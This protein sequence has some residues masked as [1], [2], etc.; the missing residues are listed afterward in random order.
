M[1]PNYLPL[2]TLVKNLGPQMTGLIYDKQAST[3][4]FARVF[5]E[6]VTTLGETRPH[7]DPIP[8]YLLPFEA[9]LFKREVPKNSVEG[10]EYIVPPDTDFKA[11]IDWYGEATGATFLHK[12]DKPS[13]AIDERIEY[14]CDR[15]GTYASKAGKNPNV[16]A[17]ITQK[18]SKKVGCK[19]R[20]IV[21]RDGEDMFIKITGHTGHELGKHPDLI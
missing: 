4:P 5:D 2:S 13:S 19:A 18:P 11:R 17:R 14:V 20:I 9:T 7:V 10:H 16:K 1:P 8:K 21:S 6:F 12:S 15:S 3:V